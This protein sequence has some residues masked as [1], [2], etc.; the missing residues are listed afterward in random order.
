MR[1]ESASD[2]PWRADLEFGRLPEKK[3]PEKKG[4]A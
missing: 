4:A 1:E 3:G 2:E